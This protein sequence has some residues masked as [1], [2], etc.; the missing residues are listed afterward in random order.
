LF[1]DP[2]TGQ[3]VFVAPGKKTSETKSSAIKPP[4]Q[5]ILEISKVNNKGLISFKF[6]EPVGLEALKKPAS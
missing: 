3:F 6:S 5:P 1:I 2:A 4:Q